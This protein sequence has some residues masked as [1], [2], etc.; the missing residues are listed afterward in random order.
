MAKKHTKEFQVRSLPLVQE[1]VRIALSSDLSRKQTAGDLGMSFPTLSRWIQV[2]RHLDDV[3][4][5]SDT[6]LEQEVTRLCKKNRLLKEE[7]DVL[8]GARGV[9]KATQFFA[10]QEHFLAPALRAL[11]A[12]GKN[13]TVC[14]YTSGRLR[15]Q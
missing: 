10:P 1:A 2:H 11:R 9:K 8:Q 4:I 14:L 3:S 6:S 5:P 12:R 7:R 13:E 15:T